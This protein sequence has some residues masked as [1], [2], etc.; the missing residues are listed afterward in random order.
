MKTE[1]KIVEPSKG[2][3]TVGTFQEA[4]RIAADFARKNNSDVLVYRVEP[5]GYGTI[6][7]EKMLTMHPHPKGTE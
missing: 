5:G 2:T 1:Y 4:L 6:F 7:Y 3:T